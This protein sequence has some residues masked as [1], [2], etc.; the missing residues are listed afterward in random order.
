MNRYPIWKYVVIAFAI[1]LSGLYAAPNIFGEVPAVQVSGVR[2][3]NKIDAEL[4]SRLEAALKEA[5]VPTLVTDQEETALRFRFAD[6]DMQLRARDAIQAKVGPG[7]VV[8]LNLV[9]NS[10]KWLQAI[11]SKPMYLGLDL[12]GGVHFLLQVD[13]KGATNKALDRYLNDAR[14]LMRDKKI[15][16]SGLGREGTERERI[17]IRFRESDQRAAALKVLS[18]QMKD[19]KSVV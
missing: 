8:A 4:R 17:V 15:Y 14:S 5:N 12:R 3:T 13:M 9:P 2:M 19:R 7:Y 11:G 16:Y 18:D 10:P 1:L 6:T